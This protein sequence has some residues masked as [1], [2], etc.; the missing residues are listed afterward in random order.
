MR[1]HNHCFIFFLTKFDS[2]GSG[3][4][5]LSLCFAQLLKRE[6]KCSMS[7]AKLD[8]SA[9]ENGNR[10]DLCWSVKMCRAYRLPI[11]YGLSIFG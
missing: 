8:A 7:W 5:W 6:R 10:F 2:D 1:V 11:N 4:K 9:S 3:S